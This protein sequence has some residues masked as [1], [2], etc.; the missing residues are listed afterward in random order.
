MKK[1]LLLVLMALVLMFAIAGCGKGNDTGSSEPASGEQKTVTWKF[2]LAEGPNSSQDVYAKAFKENIEKI[3]EGKITVQIFYV[4]QL[5]SGSTQGELIQNG[6]V[7]MGFLPAGDAGT[8]IPEANIFSLH[9]IFPDDV[10]KAREMIFNSKVMNEDIATAYEAN[11]LHIIDWLDEGFMQWTANKVIASPADFKGFKMRVMSSPILTASY[12]AYGASPVNVPYNELYSALQLKMAEGQV[13][14]PES[15][16]QMKFYE[17]QSHM[18]MGNSD[19]FLAS[20]VV[21][22]SFWDGLSKEMQD[23]VTATVKEVR[24]YYGAEQKIMSE[25]CL[26]ELEESGMIITHLKPEV[27]AEFRELAKKAVPEYIKI[28]GPN[29]QKLYDDFIAE[30]S[31]YY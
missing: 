7:E 28:G 18:T 16:V 17:V 8:I 13:N 12:Q 25:K 22:K 1:R 20:L 26:K 5:G 4:G 31:T 11:N 6:A 2:A 14:P 29:A 19:L 10:D 21:G 9:Y 15:I 24:P 27:V 3:S 30:A 23:I